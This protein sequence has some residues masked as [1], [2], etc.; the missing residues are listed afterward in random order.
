MQVIFGVDSGDELICSTFLNLWKCAWCI[1]VNTL[2]FW[3]VLSLARMW[4]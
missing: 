2:N 4:Q 1:R 3:L